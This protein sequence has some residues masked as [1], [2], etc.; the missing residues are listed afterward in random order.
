MMRF[1]A[2]KSNPMYLYCQLLVKLKYVKIMSSFPNW[3]VCTYLWFSI[4]T[5]DDT[6]DYKACIWNL[7]SQ[8]LIRQSAIDG[9]QRLWLHSEG[10]Q[11]DAKVKG[12]NSI[13]KIWWQLASITQPWTLLIAI[14]PHYPTKHHYPPKYDGR[15]I[16]LPD[17]LNIELYLKQLLA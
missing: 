10:A 1:F 5:D 15:T 2:D 14:E 9:P 11:V 3:Y 17:P 7:A 4:N 13:C 8:T 16:P 6:D 12:V